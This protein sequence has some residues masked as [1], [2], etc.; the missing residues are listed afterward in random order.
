MQ[1]IVSIS[2]GRIKNSTGDSKVVQKLIRIESHSGRRGREGIYY[3][4][5][6]S[7]GG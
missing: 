6:L 7:V 5:K 2:D 3:R 1:G 4:W